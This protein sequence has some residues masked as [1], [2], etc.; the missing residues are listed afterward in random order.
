MTRHCEFGSVVSIVA[1]TVCNTS[2]Y[3][4]IK[5]GDDDKG[6]TSTNALQRPNKVEY[7]FVVVD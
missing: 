2:S 6:N 4:P 1:K 5:I 7:T 3:K